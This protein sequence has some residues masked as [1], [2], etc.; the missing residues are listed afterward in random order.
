MYICETICIYIIQISQKLVHA[1]Y[2]DTFFSD[3]V[4]YR[5]S[6]VNAIQCHTTEKAYF[7]MTL[8]NQL[9]LMSY[10]STG[11][12]NQRCEFIA[13]QLLPACDILCVQESWH[14]PLI[15]PR[16][17]YTP[18]KKNQLSPLR[19]CEVLQAWPFQTIPSYSW[20]LSWIRQRSSC[21]KT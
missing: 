8:P 16:K 12:N 5:P 2:V 20:P 19:S 4:S 7:V 17:T 13:K 14:I 21:T 3:M 9:R 15:L 6:L 10:N 18:I 1:Q 11:F